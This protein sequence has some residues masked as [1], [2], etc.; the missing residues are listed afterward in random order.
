MR[1]ID[2]IIIHCSATSE[3]KEFTIEDIDRWH[4]ERGFDCI[5]YHFVVLR[6]GRVQNGRPIEKIGAH[7]KDHNSETIAI[8]YIGGLQAD[9]KIAKDTRTSEQKTALMTL[10]KDL[11]ENYPSIRKISGHN[12]YAAKACPSFDV[13]SDLLGMLV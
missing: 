8:C 3:E 10:C 2:E 7:T 1:Y 9:G 5:G 11:L 13:R 12:E 6:D 4:R